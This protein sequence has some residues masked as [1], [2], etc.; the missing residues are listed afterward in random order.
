MFKQ[1]KWI[2]IA[3]VLIIV[4]GVYP[5]LGTAEGNGED[6]AAAPTSETSTDNAKASSSTDGDGVKQS[7]AAAEKPA[8]EQA[9]NGKE[10][11]SVTAAKPAV[12]AASPATDKL[13]P[14]TAVRR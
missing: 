2:L 6:T 13:S 14:V 4:V 8:A 7:V 9:G 5:Y 10:S 3:A 12:P 1:R 11:V